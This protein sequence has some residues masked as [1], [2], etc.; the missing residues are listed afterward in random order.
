MRINKYFKLFESR[1]SNLS[2][3]EFFKLLKENCQDFIKNPKPLQRVKHDSIMYSYINPKIHSRK[4]GSTASIAKIINLLIDNLPSWKEFPKRNNSIIASSNIS[5]YQ[6]S[7]GSEYYILIP[8]DGAKFGVTPALDLWEVKTRYLPDT[9]I[10]INLSWM[11][12]RLKMLDVK[13]TSYKEFMDDLQSIYNQYIYD[14]SIFKD[15]DH[16]KILFNT[17]I[18]DNIENVEDGFNIYLSPS[19]LVTYRKKGFELNNYNDLKTDYPYEIW[20]DSECILYS[21]G[22]HNECDSCGGTGITGC[23]ECWGI[24]LID[25]GDG[26]EIECN[27]CNNGDVVCPECDGYEPLDRD[28]EYA[29]FLEKIK[30]I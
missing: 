8:F 28:Q 9:N 27:N 13:T 15:R 20:T 4:D 30:K 17:F 16:L 23:D 7:Y 19:N 26:N 29:K 2:E 12:S 24:G 6:Q 11:Q 10:D 5:T 21:L 18:N 1:S 22:F 3:E 14:K 25:D